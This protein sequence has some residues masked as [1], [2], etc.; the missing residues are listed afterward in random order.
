MNPAHTPMNLKKTEP[1]AARPE[2]EDEEIPTMVLD[3]A[4]F[5]TYRLLRMINQA[6]QQMKPPAPQALPSR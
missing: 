3:D 5:R 2:R 4:P 1:P 6:A